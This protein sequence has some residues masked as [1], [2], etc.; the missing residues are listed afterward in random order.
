MSSEELE[1]F[2]ILKYGSI[3]LMHDQWM[4]GEIDLEE[5]EID[6]LSNYTSIT[7]DNLKRQWL[8]HR[9]VDYGIV[10]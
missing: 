2:L 7:K 1:V 4:A 3:P 9:R 8:M 5:H 6:F 10:Q